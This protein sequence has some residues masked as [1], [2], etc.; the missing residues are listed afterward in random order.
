MIGINQFLHPAKEAYVKAH[1]AHWSFNLRQWKF[2]ESSDFWTLHLDT[3]LASLVA[4]VL[5]LALFTWVVHR[6]KQQQPGKLQVAVEMSYEAIAQ[7]TRDTLG[8]QD[9]FALA[10]AI[11]SFG[12]ILLMNACD[13]L[14]VD[15]VP[16]LLLHDFRVVPTDD[17]NCTFALSLTIF[18]ICNAYLWYRKGPRGIVREL[19]LEPFGVWLAPFNLLFN[20]LEQL[21]RPLSLSLRLYGNMFAG[22]LIFLLIAMLPWWAQWPV[23]GAWAIF[24]LLVIAIQAFI[25]MMLTLIYIS[26]ARN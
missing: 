5:L 11:A 19:L 25:F 17:P 7:L 3:M 15:L 23:G 26:M 1:L 13:L 14:P 8:E 4:A 2:S 18:I 24:H 16:R 20:L 21:V 9:D 10:V 22:E 6:F 12:W